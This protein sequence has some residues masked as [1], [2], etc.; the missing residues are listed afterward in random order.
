MILSYGSFGFNYSTRVRFGKLPYIYQWFFVNLSFYG[1]SK[2]FSI[3]PNHFKQVYTAIMEQVDS[4][5]K[6]MSALDGKNLTE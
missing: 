4:N 5:K 6:I 2:V 1:M 3:I